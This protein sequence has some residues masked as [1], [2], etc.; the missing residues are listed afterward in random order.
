MIIFE[1]YPAGHRMHYVRYIAAEALKRGRGVNLVTFQS[2]LEHP[3]T[4]K[5]V[6]ECKEVEVIIISEKLEEYWRPKLNN[7]NF[8]KR[9]VNHHRMFVEKYRKLSV[10]KEDVIF[11]PYLDYFDFAAAVLG[12]P[13]GDSAWGGIVFCPEFYST[14]PRIIAPKSNLNWLRRILYNQ[15]IENE[16]LKAMHTVNPVLYNNLSKSDLISREK[17]FYVPV[18]VEVEGSGDKGRARERLGFPQE[19][20][21]MLVYGE[22]TAKKGIGAL[23]SAMNH[24]LFPEDVKVILAGPQDARVAKLLSSRGCDDLRRAGRLFEV[25]RFLIGQ[26]E[27]DVFKA[28]DMVWLGYRGVFGQSDVLFQ[29]GRMRL[30]VVA[31]RHGVVGFMV[32]KHDLGLTVRVGDSRDVADAVT[33]LVQDTALASRYAKQGFESARQHTREN[34]AKKICDSLGFD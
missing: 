28:S 31:A 16:K 21:F 9:K 26:E 23:L 3:A 22:L 2:S 5:L 17:L 18:P 34:F 4:Q 32:R 30:P 7:R 1:P 25:N 27:Y 33:A 24:A 20:V 13:F 15:L 29:A 12:A 10:G 11:V 19:G 8:V 6:E 14:Y